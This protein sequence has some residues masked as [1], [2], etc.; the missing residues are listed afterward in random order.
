VAGPTVGTDLAGDNAIICKVRDAGTVKN[1]AAH[2]AVGVDMDGKKEV[3]GIWV[4]HTEGAKFWLRVMNDLKARGI[5]D[6]LIVVC[7]GLVGLPAAVEAVWPQTVVQT[8]IVH[9][10]RASLRWVNYKD[11]KRVAAQLRQIYAAPTEQAAR[12]ALDTWTDSDIG[13]KYPAIKRQWETAWEQ[14]IPFFAFPP[15]IRRVVYTTDEI[16]KIMLGSGSADH[17]VMVRLP[18]LRGSSI[19]GHLRRSAGAVKMQ[20][21]TGRTILTAP[22]TGTSSKPEEPR[23]TTGEH[24][25]TGARVPVGLV[26]CQWATKTW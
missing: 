3:L 26:G 1:K 12:D 21:P 20:R 4:E 24:H 18:G 15:E 19:A 25:Q 7:D 23:N 5:E 22:S 6:V 13:R 17:L 11:R 8:C 14:V 9:L 10:T 2:L 16:V